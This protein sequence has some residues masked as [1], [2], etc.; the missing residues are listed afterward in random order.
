M[1][2]I[3]M[4]VFYLATVTTSTQSLAAIYKCTDKSGNI[5]F[6]GQPCAHDAKVIT[7]KTHTPSADDVA[8]AQNEITELGNEFNNSKKQRDI[9]GIEEEIR[10]KRNQMDTEIRILRE[11]Q[12]TASNNIAGAQYYSGLATEM[13]AVTARYQGE[14]DM[15]QRRIQSMRDD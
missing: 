3:A 7:V 9:A 5:V 15:L 6:S 2:R 4:L 8:R 14:I 11:R 10:V 12:S 13:Q 1:S